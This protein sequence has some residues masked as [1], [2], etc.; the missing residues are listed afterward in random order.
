MPSFQRIGRIGPSRFGPG[1]RTPRAPG[2]V[3]FRSTPGMFGGRVIT[4]RTQDGTGAI[5][6]SCD[7]DLFQIADITV[8]PFV[9]AVW[10]AMM[11]SDPTTGVYSFPIPQNDGTVFFTRCYKAGTPVFGTSDNTLTGLAP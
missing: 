10:V 3:L 11:V 7:V 6:G 8:S 1:G 4:G 5:L 9:R 2:I